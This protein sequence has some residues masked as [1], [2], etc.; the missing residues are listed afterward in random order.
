MPEAHAAT[1]LLRDGFILLGSALAFVLLFRQLGLG[2]TLG[3]LVAGAVREL[4]TSRPLSL[5]GR[6]YADLRPRSGR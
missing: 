1:S 3:Y 2:A 4:L 5:D 6:G